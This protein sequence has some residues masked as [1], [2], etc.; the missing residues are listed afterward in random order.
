MVKKLSKTQ[1]ALSATGQAWNRNKLRG[2][3]RLDPEHAD[4]KSRRRSGRQ[5]PRAWTVHGTIAVSFG[6]LG[7]L[8]QRENR[9]TK[10]PLDAIA[11]VSLASS[12][13]QAEAVK[14]VLSSLPYLHICDYYYLYSQR[15]CLNLKNIVDQAA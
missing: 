1:A 8:S 4:R 11:A 3:D 15:H 6:R 5:H 13:H 12:Q 2:G 10:R 7:A 14:A 9:D